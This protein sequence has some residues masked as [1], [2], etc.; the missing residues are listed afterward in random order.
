MA[1]SVAEGDRVIPATL[2]GAVANP[3]VASLSGAGV[4]AAPPRVGFVFNATGTTADVLWDDGTADTGLGADDGVG[5]ACAVLKL[6]A[7]SIVADLVGRVVQR[8]DHDAS[9]EFIGVVL[10]VATIVADPKTPSAPVDF[11]VVQSVGNSQIYWMALAA[12]VQV[13]E[14]R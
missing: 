3:L 1:L 9:G 10:F 13:L 6:G 8:T 5:T 12:D 11:V 2:L 14:G 4:L 7:S